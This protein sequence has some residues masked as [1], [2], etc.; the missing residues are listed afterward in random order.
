[1]IL[2]CW[3]RNGGK[4]KFALYRETL[5]T[6]G[7]YL[8]RIVIVTREF[9]T[10]PPHHSVAALPEPSANSR[11]AFFRHDRI[12]R[13][14]EASAS[15]GRGAASRW[16]VPSPAK[17]RGGR[18]ALCPSSAMSSDRLFLDRVARQHCPSLLHRHPDHK[19]W[20]DSWKGFIIGR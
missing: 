17:E 11:K 13:S 12:Y 20:T 18:N 16:S 15:R 4:P 6:T 1:M 9:A 14:D 3:Q 7:F 8:G 5:R 2:V 19:L 10:I